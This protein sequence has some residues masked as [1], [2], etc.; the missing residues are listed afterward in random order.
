MRVAYSN[1]TGRVPGLFQTRTRVNVIVIV[2]PVNHDDHHT[3]IHGRMNKETKAP[4]IVKSLVQ[5]ISSADEPSV[6]EHH[7]NLLAFLTTP[8][9]APQDNEK[10]HDGT[11]LEE[12]DDFVGPSQFLEVK[13]TFA[14][15]IETKRVVI[16][17]CYNHLLPL[18]VDAM[19]R[20]ERVLV[21]GSPGIGKGLFGLVLLRTVLFS[22]I[23]DASPLAQ[24]QAF[25]TAVYWNNELVTAISRS[26][27][28]KEK[29]GLN[30]EYELASK[31]KLFMGSW[32]VSCSSLDNLLVEKEI[33]VVHDPAIDVVHVGKDNRN[34]FLQ[35]CHFAVDVD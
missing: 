11:L 17:D 8:A 32:N 16:R 34:G 15:Q 18:V 26:E 13:D 24:T 4:V 6:E 1:S 7:K 20:G 19:K 35:T 30:Q 21:T 22:N 33:A 31:E 28:Y 5:A 29:Y 9:S 12:N 23:L 25:H 27:A 2:H 14:V 3:V 10:M